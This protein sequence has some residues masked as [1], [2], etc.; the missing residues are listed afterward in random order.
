MYNKLYKFYLTGKDIT[1]DFE[2]AT[3]LWAIYLKPVM[4]FYVDFMGYISELLKRPT[5]VHNDLWKMVY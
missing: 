1:L 3:E 4:P 5:R 2:T